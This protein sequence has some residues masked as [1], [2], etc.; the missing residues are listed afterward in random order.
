DFARAFQLRQLFLDQV[1]RNRETDSHAG[2]GVRVD[3]AIDSN[4]VA[5]QIDQRSARVARIYRRVGLD[6]ILVVAGDEASL[7]AD[8]S[9]RHRMIE[10]E[11]IADR[12][13]PL[14]DLQV[15]RVAKR[16]DGKIVLHV[17]LQQRDVALL[18][19]PDNLRGVVVA[20]LQSYRDGPRTLDD[21]LVGQDVAVPG[22]D[23]AGAERLGMLLR[24]AELLERTVR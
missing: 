24:A 22:D 9:G 8:D 16:R 12:H 11:R 15:T 13:H 10:A 2:A 23:E 17:D 21:V 4:D 5:A 3:R 14:A 18:V 6:E 7:G 20:V 19:M 1:D